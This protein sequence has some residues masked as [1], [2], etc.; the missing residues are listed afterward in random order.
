M[1]ART[2]VWADPS[3][4]YTSMLMGPV[5]AY[6]TRQSLCDQRSKRFLP[7]VHPQELCWFRF[8]FGLL[9]SVISVLPSLYVLSNPC[10]SP[11]LHRLFDTGGK[12][13]HLESGRPGFDSH[14]RRGSFSKSSHVSDLKLG[15]PVA[16]LPGT[17]RFTAGAGTGWPGVRRL[18][19][20]ELDS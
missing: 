18:W 15:T 4:R 8:S 9:F 19:L 3:P 12:G 13:V 7:V 5:T 14:L 2:I 16:T 10:S 20:G 17:W 6:L 1:V 11:G